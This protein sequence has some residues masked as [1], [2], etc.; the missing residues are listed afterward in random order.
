M[1]IFR[2]QKNRPLQF[3]QGRFF[4]SDIILSLLFRILI[5]MCVAMPD[6]DSHVYRYTESGL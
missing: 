1:T 4:S 5:H 6:Q 3:T 2:A